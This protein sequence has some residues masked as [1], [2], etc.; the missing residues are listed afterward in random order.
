MG[1]S[2]RKRQGSVVEVGGA[3]ET[4]VVDT[5]GGR[6]HVR[7]D[8]GA[9]ATPHGQLVFFAEFLATTGVFDRWVSAC[10]LAYTSGNA[11][12][13]RDVLGTLM[14]GLLAG[15]RRYAHITAL[16][17]DAVAAQAL[18]M[19]KV[20]SEDALRRALERIDEA[21]STAWMRPA[22]MHSVREVLDK[23]W[24]L[25]IDASIKP[26]HGRQEGAEIGYNP[27]KPG[28]P[29]HVLHT[30]W[31]GNLRGLVQD[32][33]AYQRR[34][35]FM[36][37][38]PT[39]TGAGAVGT[40]FWEFTAPLNLDSGSVG[41]IFKMPPTPTAL[42]SGPAFSL[43][44]D[45]DATL[46]ELR[47]TNATY[48]ESAMRFMTPPDATDLATVRRRGAEIIAYHGVSD[49]IFSVADTEAWY[50][51]ENQKSGGR[52]DSFVRL[53][54]MPGM[55][56]CSGG[57]STDQADYLSTLVAGSN[58]AWR[59]GPSWSARAAPATPVA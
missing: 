32:T 21:S 39:C 3:D 26:L 36:R 29:S 23:P 12:S 31:V 24:V 25:D 44:L 13:K 6:M 22:L 7:W 43:G 53:Y 47:A 46:A 9:S 58:A 50:R 57:P 1:E 35:N 5:L 20:V 52:A 42:S 51:G 49:A 8:E 14:L 37:D 19:N 15:H 55:G 28:R 54:P 59:Q 30:F 11:P 34:C 4:Q 45:I 38:V 33:S 48:T 18:G 2:K 10:P 17:G 40:S 56:H 41:V 27:A 16:R